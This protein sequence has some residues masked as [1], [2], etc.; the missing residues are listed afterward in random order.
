MEDKGRTSFYIFIEKPKLLSYHHDGT[1]TS[2]RIQITI[3]PMER[4]FKLE[5][6]SRLQ[7]Y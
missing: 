5:K 6:T 7:L 4:Y 2:I 3:K 1:A